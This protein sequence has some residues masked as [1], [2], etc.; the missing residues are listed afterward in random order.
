VHEK[1]E[2]VAGVSRVIAKTSDAH[3]ATFEVEGMAGTNVRPE[4]ARAVV[5]AGW[6]LNELRP[7]GLSLEEVF[8]QLTSVASPTAAAPEAASA[9]PQEEIQ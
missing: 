3:R 4:V 6:N 5:E 7:L 8:L 2:R 9:E 1:L